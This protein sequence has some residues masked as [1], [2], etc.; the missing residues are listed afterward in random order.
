ME[1]FIFWAVSINI[2]MIS[3]TK[4]DDSLPKVQFLIVGYHSDFRFD[5]NKYE[6]M[7]Y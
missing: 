6:M 1:N 7:K 5:C 3:E 4:L 2:L